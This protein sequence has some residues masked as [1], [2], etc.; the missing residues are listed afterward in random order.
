MKKE[1]FFGILWGLTLG[2]LL[3][4]LMVSVG[5]T[6][7]VADSSDEIEISI[8]GDSVKVNIDKDGIEKTIIINGDS[9]IKTPTGITVNNEI[10]IDDGKIIIDGVEISQDE[11]RR[12][13][14]N[15]DQETDY[16]FKHRENV[17][18]QIKR[19]RLATAYT[20]TGRDIVKFQNLEIDSATVVPG[21]VISISGDITIRGR[22][23][24]D[25][26]SIFGNVY[27]K[28]GARI[29]GDV[30]APFG[31]I[32]RDQNVEIKGRESGR[33][34]QKNKKNEVSLGMTARFNRIEGLTIVPSLTY[35]DKKG[36]LPTLSIISAYAFTL[37]RW[38]YDFGV[39]H[40]VGHSFGPYF[41]AHLYQLA[42]TPDRW[43]LTETE[44]SVAGLFFKEDFY[45]L[46]WTRGFTGE[47][48]LFSGQNFEAGLEFTAAKISNLQRTAKKAIFGGHKKFRS[49]WSTILPDSADI[50]ASAG[51]LGE[52]AI[53]TSYDTRDEKEEPHTGLLANLEY[54]QAVKSSSSDFNYRLISGE[55][56]S[57]FSLTQN[58]TLFF[59]VR[60]GFSDDQLPLFH[61]F[62]LGGIGSLRGYEFKEF[63]GNRYA[64]FN[65]DYI[66]RFFHSDMGAGLFFD[67][68]KASTGEKQFKSGGLKSDVGIA[69]IVEDAFRLDLAQRLD[70]LDKSPVVMARLQILF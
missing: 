65:A 53:K 17:Q 10:L 34:N 35:Q 13:S 46:Y 52:L 59:R 62:F 36:D 21:D 58:Q 50:I 64:L 68:G 27:L 42:E 55:V 31:H 18:K 40:R 39:K 30:T 57:Y 47:A 61:Q 26:V 70:D 19:K 49:N 51:D 4:A 41:S 67:T 9:L 66:W 33:E 16:H 56:K 15:Q 1:I 22:V 48:G 63:E 28:D 3:V 43:R 37:K 12:L 20:D 8:S 24:G 60:G 14:V 25:V 38:E 44:N 54:R 2:L 45:D 7:V 69:L 5:K 32:Y 29:H 11:L 6:A 23:D